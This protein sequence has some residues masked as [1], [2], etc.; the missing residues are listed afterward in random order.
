LVIEDK[1]C[2][3]EEFRWVQDK[4]IVLDIRASVMGIQGRAERVRP[5]GGGDDAE[6][7]R[8][9]IVFSF[10]RRTRFAAP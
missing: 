1:P 2:R 8:P 10:S 9:F 3:D 6:S 5:R 4:K 7:N